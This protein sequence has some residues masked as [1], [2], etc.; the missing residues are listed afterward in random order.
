MPLLLKE[1]LNTQLIYILDPVIL[2]NCFIVAVSGIPRYTSNYCCFIY[3][4]H[5]SI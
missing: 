3:G 1:Q 5:N 4:F 2:L